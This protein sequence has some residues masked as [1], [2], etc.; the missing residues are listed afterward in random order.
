MTVEGDADQ[1]EVILQTDGG[2]HTSPTGLPRR[3][4]AVCWCKRAVKRTRFSSRATVMSPCGHT[5]V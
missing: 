2:N 1:D 3:T 5:G 4:W